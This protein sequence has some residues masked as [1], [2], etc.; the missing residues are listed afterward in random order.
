MRGRFYTSGRTL[1][2]AVVFS[3]MALPRTRAQAEVADLKEDVHGLS[4]R[5]NELS[6]RVEQLEHDNAELRAK[7][8]KAEDN[9]DAVTEAQL[10]GA[11]ADLNASV[12]AAVSASRAEIL[13]QVATQMEVLAK[14][15]NAALDSI[16][17]AGP[18]PQVRAAS[19]PPA[20]KP[21]FGDSYPKE[22]I[23]YT[24]AKGDT[25]GLI[26]KKTGA[27]AQDIIDANKLLDPSRI[28]T[29]QVLF[30]PGGK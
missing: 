24:V 9:R 7:L 6:L 15:T 16:A 27:K 5:V 8:S 14:Q 13:H 2:C 1:V 17:K 21:A 26:A 30:V 29:G 19:S 23:S 22:G 12:A 4:Q 28:Q 20:P 18:Q 10:N 11:V 3:S 25:V